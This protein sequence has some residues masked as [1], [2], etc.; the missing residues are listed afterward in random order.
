MISLSS[1]ISSVIKKFGFQAVKKNRGSVYITQ[2][3]RAHE[4][5][6]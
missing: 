3:F 6:P 2:R 1:Q 4:A 5:Q